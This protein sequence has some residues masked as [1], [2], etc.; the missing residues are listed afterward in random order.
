MELP[1]AQERW[2][3]LKVGLTDLAKKKVK[4]VEAFE[5][6][7]REN[8]DQKSP[9]SLLRMVVA[10]DKHFTEEFFCE[11][12]LPWIASKALQVEELFDKGT[13]LPASQ[14]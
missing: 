4:G 8:D 5:Q 2:K 7:V 9:F 3:N 10:N 13:R 12:L 1:N 6:F 11:T 14:T